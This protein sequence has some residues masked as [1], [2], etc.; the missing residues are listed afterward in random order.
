MRTRSHW[1]ALQQAEESRQ[2]ASKTSRDEEARQV[3][4]EYADDQRAII[5]KLRCKRVIVG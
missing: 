2:Q 1:R 4:K 5:E 3:V